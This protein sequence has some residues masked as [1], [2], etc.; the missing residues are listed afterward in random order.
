M[1][2]I[3]PVIKL[4]HGHIV[5]SIVGEEC[6][7]GFYD[8]LKQHPEKLANLLRRENSKSLMFFDYDSFMGEDNQENLDLIKKV[9]KSIDIPI[10]YVTRIG[11]VEFAEELLD[12][13]IYRIYVDDLLLKQPDKVRK[14]VEKYSP[15]RVCSY[16]LFRGGELIPTDKS[17]DIGIEDWIRLAKE[18]G[19]KRMLYAEHEVMKNRQNYDF[20]T[21]FNFAKSIQMQITLV[22]G[23]HNSDLLNKFSKAFPPY[24]DSIALWKALWEN[25][26]PCQ[27][28]WRMVEAELEN[29]GDEKNITTAGKLIKNILPD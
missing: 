2:L 25:D 21:V 23:V 12:M 19:L 22:E 4:S 11:S 18:G 24:I 5:G 10:Q 17:N 26:F 9:T 15:S 6:M 3:I 1:I 27:K 16:F 14:L 29:S 20:D 8:H 7:R 13:G 28:I